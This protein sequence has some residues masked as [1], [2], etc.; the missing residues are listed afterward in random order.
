MNFPS[1]TGKKPQLP[2]VPDEEIDALAFCNVAVSFSTR[3]LKTGFAPV[4]LPN[5]YPVKHPAASANA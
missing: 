4:G 5:A 1:V 3:H 2:Y